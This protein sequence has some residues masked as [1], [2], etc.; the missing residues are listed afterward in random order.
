MPIKIQYAV[1][2]ETIAQL[3]KCGEKRPRL[4]ENPERSSLFLVARYDDD[5]VSSWAMGL[6]NYGWPVQ[7]I[8]QQNASLWCGQGNRE[9]HGGVRRM[10]S[11]LRCSCA[12]IF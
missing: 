10:F 11:K 7:S 8:C 6:C 9:M 12:A 1:T 3:F 2:R 5:H 4:L